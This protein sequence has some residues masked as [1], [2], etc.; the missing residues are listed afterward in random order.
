MNE[1]FKKYLK[2]SSVW[3]SLMMLRNTCLEQNA[4]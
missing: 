3:L 4:G 2:V 1:N